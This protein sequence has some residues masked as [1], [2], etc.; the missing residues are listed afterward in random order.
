M[1]MSRCG[2]NVKISGGRPENGQIISKYGAVP[3]RTKTPAG[4]PELDYNFIFRHASAA[5]AK[6]K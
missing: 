2:G 4:T 6:R 5:G 3:G 1:R